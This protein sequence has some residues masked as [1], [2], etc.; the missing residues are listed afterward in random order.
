MKREF[1]TELGLEKE[2][3]DKIMAENGKDIAAEKAKTTAAEAS[4]AE[5]QTTLDE[6]NTT[7]AGFREKDL[8]VDKAQKLAK[9][10]ERKYEQAEQARAEEKRNN[11]LMQELAKTNT[12]DAELLR[13]CLDQE[14][15]IYK[16]DKFIGLEDQLATIKEN[17]PYLF[18]EPSKPKMK[19]AHLGEPSDPNTPGEDPVDFNTMTYSEITAYLEKHPEAA[20]QLR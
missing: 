12:V 9:D 18:A 1:L 10:W 4:L 14:A 5:L 17:K 15:L 3:I 19:G 11:A 20:S 7:I 2:T 13:A 16:D 8:D 6:A